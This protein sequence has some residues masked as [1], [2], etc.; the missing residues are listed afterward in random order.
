MIILIEND[1]KIEIFSLDFKPD[2]KNNNFKPN[3]ISNKH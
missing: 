3:L 2:K 1:Q